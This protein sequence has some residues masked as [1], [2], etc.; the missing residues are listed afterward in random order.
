MKSY[1]YLLFFL[2]LLF[3]DTAYGYTRE[4]VL[5]RDAVVCGISQNV[6]GF[7]TMD[8]TGRWVGFDS[9]ICRAVAAAVLGDAEKTI[10]VPMGARGAYTA[11]LSGEVDLLLLHQPEGEWNFVRDST[12]A[13]NIAGVSFYDEPGVMVKA[14]SGSD[15]SDFS[16][17]VP[18]LSREKN[19]AAAFFLSRHTFEQEGMVFPE[20]E[21][22]IRA[23]MD[24]KCDLLFGA[25]SLLQ[26]MAAT[27]S[28]LVVFPQKEG[29][30]LF[31]PIVRQGDDNW[32][33]IVRWTLLAM[34]NAEALGISSGNV[35]EMRLSADPEITHFFGDTSAGSNL[36][37][38][39][40]WTAQIVTQVG[41]Y[42]ELFVRNLGEPSLLKRKRERN[43]LWKNGG[44]HCPPPL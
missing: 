19:S 11:L 1:R 16:A 8:E 35:K 9:D 10:F 32:F 21:Q 44:L 33:D 20:R 38:A 12:L 36:G 14:V 26:G 31:G 5:Q 24:D 15:G 2:S 3:F 23:F 37:L 43:Q 30:I 7:A 39:D 17:G 4:D 41:N 40:D 22:A 6:P 28:S 18:C 34:L 27:D 42:G 29:R 13:V 25:G